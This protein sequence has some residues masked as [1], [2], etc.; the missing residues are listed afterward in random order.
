MDVVA[1][2]EGAAWRASR[3][4]TE[5]SLLLYTPLLVCLIWAAV[6]DVR[7]RRIRNELT[8]PLIIAGVLQSFWSMHTVAPKSALAGLAVGFGLTFI[9]FAMGA[10]GGGDV[11]LMAAVGAWVGP[12]AA[13]QV[14]V[15]AA[16]A[17]SVVVLYQS[18]R[19]RRLGRSF[20][21]SALLAIN[22]VHAGDAGIDHV[23]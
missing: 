15:A 3:L 2:L 12:F 22:I 13:L 21:N 14:F 9:M 5:H 11:K 16:L 19:Q 23:S 10:I 7:T 18:I 8:L 1:C 6:Q 17:G 4:M 20:R